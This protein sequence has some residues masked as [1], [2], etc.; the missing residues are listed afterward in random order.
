[1]IMKRFS[2]IQ[3]EHCKFNGECALVLIFTGLKLSLFGSGSRSSAVAQT[4][5]FL[6]SSLSEQQKHKFPWHVS[7]LICQTAECS[8]SGHAGQDF[9]L[10]PV[11]NLSASETAVRMQPSVFAKYKSI[12]KFQG[13]P[14]TEDSVLHFL[15]L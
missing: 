10:C 1:M 15:H 5:P 9:P 14:S 7:H 13:R 12:T 11:P 6:H 4:S 8:F 3:K 2:F